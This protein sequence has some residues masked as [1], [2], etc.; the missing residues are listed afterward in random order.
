MPQTLKVKII[1][2]L[3]PRNYLFL[4]PSSK[5]VNTEFYTEMYFYKSIW[6]SGRDFHNSEAFLFGM[7]RLLAQNVVLALPKRIIYLKGSS[8]KAVVVIESSVTDGTENGLQQY[9]QA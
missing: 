4:F 5:F 9:F 3:C 7:K 2:L 6:P 1:L 8:V